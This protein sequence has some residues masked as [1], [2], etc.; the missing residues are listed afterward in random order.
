M[1]EVR[2]E[3]EERAY[4]LEQAIKDKDKLKNFTRL[5]DYLGV[6]TLIL[7]NQNSMTLLVEEMRKDR[8]TGL[9]NT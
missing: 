7:T 8:K 5:V 6:E 1:N 9:F 4:L 3:A 2:K